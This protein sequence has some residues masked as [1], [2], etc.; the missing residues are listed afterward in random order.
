MLTALV[1]LRYIVYFKLSTRQAMS[2]MHG[3]SVFRRRDWH[4]RH[5]V[6][7]AVTLSV[8][9]FTQAPPDEVQS[10]VLMIREPS[11]EINPMSQG[12]TLVDIYRAEGV[13]RV[14]I[15]FTDIDGVMRGK[16]LSLDKFASIADGTSGFC[17]CVR[18]GCRRSVIRQRAT[19]GGIQ[20]F[21]MQLIAS[22]CPERRLADEQNIPLFLADFVGE[23]EYH[24]IC[25]RNQLK[26]M[27][28]RASPQ[29]LPPAWHLNTSFLC[30]KRRLHLQQRNTIE[31]SS[32]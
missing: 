29:G 3:G 32:H 24:P 17:D 14:K 12:S 25:P 15:G 16:Y 7:F 31:T 8:S 21:Q 22:I 2:P 9:R 28:D 18:L 26:R 13:R 6:E 30:L 4:A 10:M 19:P 5:A 27:I 11:E 1:S 20:R 23:G